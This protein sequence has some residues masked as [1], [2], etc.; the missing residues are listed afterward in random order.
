MPY[1]NTRN[2]LLPMLVTGLAFV[3]AAMHKNKQA[4]L[5]IFEQIILKSKQFYTK[6]TRFT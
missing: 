1:N 5:N 6:Y 2:N 4:F 3:A